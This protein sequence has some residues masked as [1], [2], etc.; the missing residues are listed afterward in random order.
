MRPDLRELVQSGLRFL[1]EVLRLD[2]VGLAG[3]NRADSAIKAVHARHKLVQCVCEL[4]ASLGVLAETV[5]DLILAAVLKLLPVLQS[6]ESREK[7]ALRWIAEI[8]QFKRS[9]LHLSLFLIDNFFVVINLQLLF[10]FLWRH[11]ERC[12]YTLHSR[13]NCIGK[14]L[15]GMHRLL[16][17]LVTPLFLHL[18]LY[19]TYLVYFFD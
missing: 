8:W 13:L 17:F 7:L 10:F 9:L 18:H 11:F 6:I 1:S 19:L 2:L 4:S 16:T 12:L 14:R 3:D 15:A 5:K